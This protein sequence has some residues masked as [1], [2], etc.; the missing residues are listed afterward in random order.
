MRNIRSINI[1]IGQALQGQ[2]ANN[3]KQ[4]KSIQESF[5][6]GIK[7]KISQ[8]DTERGFDF[9]ED[10]SEQA[11]N[12]FRA[13]KKH[14]IGFLVSLRHGG[15]IDKNEFK[16]TKK[17][18]KQFF[19]SN[20]KSLKKMFYK[21]SKRDLE[22]KIDHIDGMLSQETE[23]THPKNLELQ[24]LE[25]KEEKDK[26]Q[27]LELTMTNI[28]KFNNIGNSLLN[29]LNKVE[30]FAALT[31]L[32]PSKKQDLSEGISS[33]KDKTKTLILGLDPSLAKDLNAIDKAHQ[34]R[35]EESELYFN[36][37]V[38]MVPIDIASK[39]IDVINN[40]REGFQD[41]ADLDR[42]T[43][44]ADMLDFYEYLSNLDQAV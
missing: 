5:L 29:L 18:V 15:S 20:K 2:A 36:Y 9:E 4:E 22:S 1:N 33:I 43:L 40:E 28:L 30:P 37:S 41:L 3:L 21:I 17:A 35:T 39:A 6:S 14:V 38:A 26:G 42:E 32:D 13:F 25:N 27:N 19:K 24:E 7:D 31:Q 34:E 12:S 8:I 16:Q 11:F 10:K 23:N 44:S